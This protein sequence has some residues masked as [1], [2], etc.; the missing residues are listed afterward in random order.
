MPHPGKDA[1]EGASIELFVVDD[2]DVRLGQNGDSAV[3]RGWRECSLPPTS[4]QRRRIARELPGEVK[5]LALAPM[6]R[7][8]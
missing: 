1:V 6:K 8:W 3:R 7:A 4:E 5:P 2:E